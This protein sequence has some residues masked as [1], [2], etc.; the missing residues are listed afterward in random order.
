MQD[1]RLS[2]A[3][4]EIA[5]LRKRLARERAAR[6]EA[7]LAAEKGFRDLYEQQSRLQLLEAIAVAANSSASVHDALEFAVTK[8][9]LY[10]GWPLGHAHLAD[11][12]FA[13]KLRPTT[14]WFVAD[15]ERTREFR[16][17]TGEIHFERGMGLPG[18]VLETGAPLWLVL[19]AGEPSSE[20]LTPRDEYA[21]RA[22]LKTALAFP[23]LAGTEVVAVLEFFSDTRQQPDEALLR[24]M[25]QIGTQLGRVAER[26]RAEERLRH[27]AN[28][29]SLTGLPNRALF[30]ARLSQL[31]ARHARDPGEGFAVLFIDLDRFKMVNDSLGHMAGDRLLVQVAARIMAALRQEDIVCRSAADGHEV[32]SRLGGDEFTVL[33]ESVGS[34]EDALRVGNRI[35]DGMTAPFMVEGQEMYVG[36]SIGVASSES[37]YASGDDAMRDADLA[38]HRAKS[39]GKGRCELYDH[40]LHALA[41]RRLALE[42]RLR[43]ADVGREFVLHYQPIVSLA[44]GDLAG[45][46]ALVRWKPQGE[47][48]V[49]PNDFIGVAEDT[50]LIVPIGAWVLGRACS[51]MREWQRRHPCDKPLT[52]SVNVSAREFA[53]P[54]LAARMGGIIAES[55]IEPGIVR[56]E[57]TESMTMGNID[58]TVEVLTRLRAL[59]VRL[60]IDDFGT[61]YSSLSYLHRLPFDVLKI[62][63]SFVLKM[64]RDEEGKQIVRTIL[65]LARSLHMEVVAEGT[66]TATHADLLRRMGCDY[67]QG[68]HY[69]RPVDEACAEQLIVAFAARDLARQRTCAG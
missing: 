51:T 17:A 54:D 9:C 36:A 7:E 61:G 13:R 59:G 48:L 33:L 37:G 53:Q 57:I 58:K 64:D 62:D 5:A 2:V 69:S 27:D 12:A 3:T 63:R 41:A 26:R 25:S 39:L 11:D 65:S 43:K 4:A 20:G 6:L 30:K 15:R 66:E 18:R 19:P 67:A 14:I 28:H 45:F 8:I 29:D 46:E 38:M 60:S 23:V 22:G 35:I 21:V 49:F 10:A 47:A 34:A 31:V 50:G 52:I 68:Y 24:L 16:R 32:L 42:T 1:T 55:G 40:S 44:S 56:L